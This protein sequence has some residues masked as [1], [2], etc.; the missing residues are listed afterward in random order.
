MGNSQLLSKF[1][2]L[3]ARNAVAT[4]PISSRGVVDL[5]SVALVSS[6]DVATRILHAWPAAGDH[7]PS[8]M[9]NENSTQTRLLLFVLTNDRA[10]SSTPGV[11]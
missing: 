9:A 11:A 4:F 3:A 1:E 10:Q 5:L 8:E 6:F 7:Y 2:P